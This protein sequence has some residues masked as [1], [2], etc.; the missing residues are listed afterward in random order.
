MATLTLLGTGAAVSD[1][2][3]TTTMLAVENE[4]SLLVIDCGGDV[5]QRL[6]ACGA[7]LDRLRS[8]VITHEHPDHVGGFPLMMEKLWLTGRREPLPVY[9]IASAVSQ[10]R[11]IHDAFDTS[12]WTG[13]PGVRFHEVG[14]EPGAVVLED[15][16]WRVTATPGSHTVPVIALRIECRRG[17]GTLAYSCD[18]SY[19]ERV[20]ALARGADLLV[21]EATG[22]GHGHASAEDAA[23][24]AAQAGAGRLLL[25]HLPPE[26]D[27]DEAGMERAREV[28]AATE[29]GEEGGRYPF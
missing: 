23:R 21:H 9:G 6:M 1:P 2:H 10:A 29:K 24:V 7:P 13:Y 26:R 28:F 12:G 27:L 5:V 18:T 4:G 3:R 16:D 25:V 17:G 14:H 15:D 22:H 20:V 19:D 11:H 8:L